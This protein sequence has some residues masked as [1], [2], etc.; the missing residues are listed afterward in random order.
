MTPRNTNTGGVLE[1]MILPAL[2]RGHYTYQTQVKAGTRCGGGSHKVDALAQKDGAK[3]LVSLKVATDWRHRRTEG[4][5][6]GH[7]LLMPCDPVMATVRM[8]CSTRG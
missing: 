5:L 6:R 2:M 4:A 7:V 1:A 3:V 8:S